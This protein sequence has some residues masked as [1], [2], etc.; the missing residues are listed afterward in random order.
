MKLKID[1]INIYKYAIISW[2]DKIRGGGTRKKGKGWCYLFLISLLQGLNDINH[3]GNFKGKSRVTHCEN[4]KSRMRPLR[5][6]TPHAAN[7]GPIR[8]HSD[9]LWP[10]TRHGKPLCYPV[11]VVRVLICGILYIKRAVSFLTSLRDS[12][13]APSLLWV[14]CLIVSCYTILLYCSQKV[15]VFVLFLGDR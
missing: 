12:T 8:H 14:R 5:L 6:I 9:N 15:I 11:D 1:Y 2:S 3:H 10:I 4:S 13:L 7:L